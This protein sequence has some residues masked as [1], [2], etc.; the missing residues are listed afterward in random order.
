MPTVKELREELDDYGDD[1]Q[2]VVIM[3]NG[4][5]RG[6]DAIDSATLTGGYAGVGLELGGVFY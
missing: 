4:E 6:I 1:V 5:H 3:P 2:V